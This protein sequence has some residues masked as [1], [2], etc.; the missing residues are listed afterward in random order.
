MAQQRGRTTPTRESLGPLATVRRYGKSQHTSAAI[1]TQLFLLAQ[2]HH[3]FAVRRTSSHGGTTVAR[4][5][6]R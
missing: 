6:H 2:N 4:S 1:I 3:I 5:S